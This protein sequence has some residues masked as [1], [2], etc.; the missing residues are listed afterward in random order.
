VSRPRRLN[1]FSYVGVHRYFLTFCTF[2]RRCV[3][4]DAETAEM[5]RTQLRRSSEDH[6]IAVS[7]YCAMPDHI[8][9]LAAGLTDQSNV[10]HFIERSKQ[11]TGFAFKHQTGERL[12][13]EGYYDHVLR[14]EDDRFA[15]AW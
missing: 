13:Q 7:A 4:S 14:E 6:G 9:L 10:K 3:L 2:D 5:V 15:Q 11:H 12:W 8:H 1:G